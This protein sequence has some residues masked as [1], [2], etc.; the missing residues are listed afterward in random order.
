MG[1]QT[2]IREVEKTSN[3]V[4]FE[5]RPKEGEGG[6]YRGFGR[7]SILGRWKVGVRSR[8]PVWLGGRSKERVQWK[9][10]DCWPDHQ[11]H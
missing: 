11:G 1:K 8:R 9:K 10:S 5:Q 6:T 2:F 3:K 4:S 7:K